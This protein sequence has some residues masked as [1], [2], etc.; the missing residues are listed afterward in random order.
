MYKQPTKD[1]FITKIRRTIAFWL[2]GKVWMAN[3]EN[4][5]KNYWFNLRWH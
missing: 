4:I 1:S 2:L 3:Y 5:K